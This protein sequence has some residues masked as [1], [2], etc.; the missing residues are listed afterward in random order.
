MSDRWRSCEGR[1]LEL[2]ADEAAFGL[3]DGEHEE[4]RALLA[5]MPDFDHHCM[6]RMAATVQLAI[7][8]NRLEPLPPSLQQRIRDRALP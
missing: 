3:G 5:M 1:I 6:E 8:G 4:L 2:L 7:V